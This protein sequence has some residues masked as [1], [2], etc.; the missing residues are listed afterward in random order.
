MANKYDY[1]IYSNNETNTSFIEEIENNTQI[2]KDLWNEI[3]PIRFLLTLKLHNGAK[4]AEFFE[5]MKLLGLFKSEKFFIIES[6][7]AKRKEDVNKE[8]FKTH[9]EVSNKS[10]IEFPGSSIVIFED[11][12]RIVPFRKKKD[13]FDEEKYYSLSLEHNIKCQKRLIDSF[14]Y[15]LSLPKEKW[16]LLNLGQ[17][18]TSLTIKLRDQPL[19]NTHIPMGAQSYILNGFYLPKLLKSIPENKWKRLKIVE[20]FLCLPMKEKFAVY[21]N[22][23]YQ[24]VI[25][26]GNLL[27]YETS[28]SVLNNTMQYLPWVVL[29]IVAV[30]MI[31]VIMALVWVSCCVKKNDSQLN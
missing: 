23:T 22:V 13:K 2:L 16:A 10:N 5:S 4:E 7:K 12:C 18:A 30:I 28:S 14:N 3:A 15:I 11:D 19:M 20:G 24:C 9:W 21:P 6:E 26:R 25:P 31:V 8:I 27:D 1:H 29:T 17:M